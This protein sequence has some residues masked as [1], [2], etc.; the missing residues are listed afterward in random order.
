MRIALAGGAY[1]NRSIIASAQRCVN[2]FPEPK[3]ANAAV[4]PDV[5]MFEGAFVHYP[6]PGLTL[7][8]QPPVLGAGRGAYRATNGD[9]YVVIGSN[10]YYVSNSWAFTLVGAVSPIQTP[11][12]MVDNGLTLVIVDGT[13]TGWA[14]DLATRRFGQISDLS[15]YGGDW[16]DY[17]DTYF[18][19]NRPGTTQWYISLSN[20]TFDML[21]GLGGQIYAGSILQAGSGYTN[22]T[23]S[24]VA[25]S[26]GTGTGATL[27]ITVAG[28]VVT[29]ATIASG[30]QGYANND[31]LTIGTLGGTGSNFSY[32]VANVHGYAFNPL[33]IV[34]KSGSADPVVAVKTLDRQ[35]WII[36]A[37]TTEV[38]AN[39]GAADFTFGEISGVFVEHG[40]IAKNSVATID[41]EI[42]WL[43]QDRQGYGI[44]VQSKGYQVEQ[45]STRAIETEFQTY[46]T[47]SD[48]VGFTFQVEGHAFYM[49]S[50]PTQNKTWVL[51]IAASQWHEEAY[52]DPN[53]NFQ[54][55]RANA[56]AF[57]YNSPLVLDWQNGR[58][59]KIDVTAYT[60]NG[61][62]ITF[63]RTFPHI[64]NDGKRLTYRE[65]IIDMQTGEGLPTQ[66]SDPLTVRLRWSDDRGKTFG[67]SLEKA[68]GTAGAYLTSLSFPRLGMARDRVFE[69]SWSAP[70][71]T[72]LNGCWLDV[73]AHKS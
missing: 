1:Q 54:R 50:F 18:V 27:S 3:P 28:G 16:V 23:Y 48:A 70:V 26:G 13:A 67:N 29:S 55:H 60:D 33:D 58:L 62:P 68:F 44:V 20:A 41:N 49:L 32:T 61:Q 17:C 30:G 21:T 37:L 11:V 38:W 7:L 65:F 66:T 52:T 34:A 15:F 22:G 14:V 45:V 8:G 57:A 42:L 53:G 4:P 47:V 73:V 63:I 35:I 71:N 36:G 5:S 10:L 12:R 46:S 64:L 24:N 6:R 40:C 59:Y 51:D 9:L 25:T 39:T 43:S 2:L 72:A 69:V 31:T 19:L 56:F